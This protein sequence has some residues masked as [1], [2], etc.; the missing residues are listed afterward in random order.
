MCEALEERARVCPLAGFECRSHEVGA[1][2][3]V[4]EPHEDFHVELV[5]LVDRRKIR[6]SEIL[7]LNLTAKRFCNF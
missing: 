5:V 2:S 1:R 6:S 4:V 3:H 7:A